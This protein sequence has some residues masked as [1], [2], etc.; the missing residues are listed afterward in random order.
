VSV[1]AFEG[2]FQSVFAVD[3]TKGSRGKRFTFVLG[4]GSARLDV[5]TFRGTISLR[6]GPSLK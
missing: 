1:R 4:S 3:M 2:E 6:R 5:E